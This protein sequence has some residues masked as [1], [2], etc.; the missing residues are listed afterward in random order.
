MDK[1]CSDCVHASDPDRWKGIFPI[2]CKEHDT[3]VDSAFKCDKWEPKTNEEWFVDKLLN[4]WR[5]P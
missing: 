4:D 1:R 5:M 2:R 3:W